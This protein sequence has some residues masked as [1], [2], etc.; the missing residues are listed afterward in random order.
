M[1]PRYYVMQVDGKFQDGRYFFI[2]PVK[3]GVF[4][5]FGRWFVI[6]EVRESIGVICVTQAI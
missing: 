3:G 5:S 6:E 4:N 1:N 2:P